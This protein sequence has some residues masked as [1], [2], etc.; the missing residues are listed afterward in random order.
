[1]DGVYSNMSMDDWKL[2][3]ITDNIS[4]YGKTDIKYFK[5]HFNRFKYT[6]NFSKDNITNGCNIL[7]IGCH[8][9]HFGYLIKHFNNN[10]NI[11]AIDNGATLAST[12]V[13]NLAQNNNIK[14]IEIN[15]LEIIKDIPEIPDNSIDIVY[16]CEILEHIAFNPISLWNIIYRKLK[17]GGVIII[18]TPNSCYHT[19]VLNN[20]INAQHGIIGPEISEILKCGTLGHHW[21]LYSISEIKDYFNSMSVDFVIENIYG[22]S[23]NLSIDQEHA[24][25]NTNIN[26]INNLQ[27]KEMYCNIINTLINNNLYPFSS[28][29]IAKVVLNKK[30]GLHISE[31]WKI[32]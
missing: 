4:S 18:T 12:Q 8:W 25:F 19:T 17:D 5:S 29:I 3:D 14:L 32:H 24:L 6:I 11:Y 1:M 23:F 28:S 21:K 13:Q 15:R 26:K 2:E 30:N 31:P 7:D 20:L 22:I 16:F 9:L 27:I 10:T